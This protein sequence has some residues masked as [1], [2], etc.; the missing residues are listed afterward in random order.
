[1]VSRNTAALRID[2]PEIHLGSECQ[3]CLMRVIG[4]AGQEDCLM[5]AIRSQWA[6]P[7][8]NSSYCQHPAANQ[9][10]NFVNSYRPQ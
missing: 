8:G 2:S 4:D 5:E 9:F 7:F 6:A 10:V 3:T 1:M